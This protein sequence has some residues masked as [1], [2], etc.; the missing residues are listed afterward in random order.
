MSKLTLNVGCGER[1]FD[2]YP[3]PFYKCINYD[4]RKLPC[5]DVVG[6]VRELPYPNECFDYILASDIIEHFPIA[7]TSSVLGEWLRVL[8]TDS[9]IEFRLPNLLAICEDYVKRHQE[10]RNDMDG[11][12]PIAHY[13]SWL[14]YGGQEYIGNF[15]YVGFDRRL[16]KFVCESMGLQEE[17]WQKDGYNMVVK[18]KKVGEPSYAEIS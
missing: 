4:F 2:A 5:V 14:L 7:E 12:V 17:S 8:K 18:M 6:D 10:N 1:V 11:G 9:I 16:F 13:F 15:H 3:H